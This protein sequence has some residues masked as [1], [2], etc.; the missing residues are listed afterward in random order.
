M[1]TTQFVS[2]LIKPVKKI[3]FLFCSGNIYLVVTDSLHANVRII[4]RIKRKCKTKYF[5]KSEQNP[6]ESYGIK[7]KLRNPLPDK[8]DRRLNMF[9]C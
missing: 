6:N 4:N 9:I 3:F 7:N 2:I 8:F 5:I 1:H